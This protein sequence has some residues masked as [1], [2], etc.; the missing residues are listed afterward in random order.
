MCWEIILHKTIT[1][2]YILQPEAWTALLLDYVL[3]DVCIVKGL[4]SYS[5][6]LVLNQREDLFAV[7]RQRSCLL[8][9]R[10]LACSLSIT[11]YLDSQSTGH[12]YCTATYLVCRCLPISLWDPGHRE[13]MGKKNAKSSAIAFAMSK[14][15]FVF[16]PGFLYLLPASIK[17]AGQIVSF[18]V[19]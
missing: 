16:D 7:L 11:K 1:I 4:R 6:Y 9:G 17:L 14:H 5:K 15:F 2:L 3:K 10:G 18:E 8:P 19:R 13:L 12:L